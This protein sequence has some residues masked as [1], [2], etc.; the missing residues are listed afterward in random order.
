MP[1][2]LHDHRVEAAE[3]ELRRGEV[4]VQWPAA[5]PHPRA[6]VAAVVR[7]GLA[8][9]GGGHRA[10]EED[11]QERPD[12]LRPFDQELLESL[13]ESKDLDRSKLDPIPTYALAKTHVLWTAGSSPCTP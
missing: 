7:L 12:E 2:D 8:D 5:L 11:A 10:G 3:P 6:E 1:E 9:P 13:A 4:Q